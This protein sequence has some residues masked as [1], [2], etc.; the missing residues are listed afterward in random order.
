MKTKEAID[1]LREEV[2]RLKDWSR[3][4]EGYLSQPTRTDIY[5]GK[6]REIITILQQGEKYRQE[7]L[8]T[9]QFYIKYYNI[10]NILKAN[11]GKETISYMKV[12]EQKYFPKEA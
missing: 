10:W 5:R 9:I 12:L 11:T 8:K 1:T 6:L 2:E 7:D 3:M 4:N